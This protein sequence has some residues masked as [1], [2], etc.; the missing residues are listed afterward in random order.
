MKTNE[1]L[2][3]MSFL[4]ERLMMGVSPLYLPPFPLEVMQVPHVSRAESKGRE[5]PSGGLSWA[6]DGSMW[7]GQDNLEDERVRMLCVWERGNNRPSNKVFSIK[8]AS[9]MP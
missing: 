6:H 5:E 9:T 2:K 7:L 3:A 1:P 4:D 8:K